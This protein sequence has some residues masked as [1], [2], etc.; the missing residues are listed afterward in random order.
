MGA[1]TDAAGAGADMAMNGD[2]Q[3]DD[4]A[5]DRTEAAPSGRLSRFAPILVIAAGLALAYWLGLVEYISL[6]AL[7]E[8][9]DALLARVSENFWL[10]AL[11]YFVTY[12][13]AVALSIPAAS[14]LTIFGGFLF[15]WFI[16]GTL[17]AFG[18]TI[19]ATVI[20]LAARS[21]IG[22]FLK[23]KAGPGVNKLAD[24]FRENAFGFLFVLRLAPVFPFFIIN[25]APA[26]FNV[27]VRT[28]VVATF[29]GILPGTYAYAYLGQGVDSVILS[30]REAGVDVSVSDLVTTEI[31]IAF[32]ALAAVA[33]IPFII[34]KLRGGAGTAG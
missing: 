19:G 15:G 12:V 25:I 29:L 8:H 11:I 6:E 17:T 34:G 7:A 23:R 4:T 22:D 3:G 1:E 13:V 16:A 2:S 9:R 14:L 27:P 32:A 5:L 21:A 24:G 33:A 26:L 18:A 28:Y 10:A 30:A 31:T 20:Y